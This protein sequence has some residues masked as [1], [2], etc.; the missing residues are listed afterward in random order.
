MM[1]K[2]AADRDWLQYHTPRNLALALVGEVGE[3][4]ECFQWRHDNDAEAG[5]PTWT[6]EE[7]THLGEEL[8][9]VL[10]YLCRLAVR[11]GIDLIR[12]VAD[13]M[14]KNALKYPVDRVRGQSKKYNQYSTSTVA[15]PTLAAS[16]VTSTTSATT[17]QAVASCVS[18][19]APSSATPASSSSLPSTNS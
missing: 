8:S 15:T 16:T 7:R 19:A 2:F 9:D 10:L 5:L 12:A 11:C 1:S 3:L 13:K 14:T 18:V 17:S 4:A 6:V